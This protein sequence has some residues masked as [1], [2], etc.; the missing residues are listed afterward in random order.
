MTIPKINIDTAL[1]A[2]YW[3]IIWTF[4]KANPIGLVTII[5][6]VPLALHFLV[7]FLR[8]WYVGHVKNVYFKVTLPREDSQKDKEKEVQKDL[9]EKIAIMQQ[10]YR[11]LYELK[12]LSIMNMVRRFLFHSDVISFEIIVEK[13][14][15]NFYV[16]AVE[17]YSGLIEKQITSFYPSAEIEPVEPIY[18]KNTKGVIKCNYVRQR[19]PYWFPIKTFKTIENDPLNAITNI[20]TKMDEDEVGAI[21]IIMRP[22]AEKIA[23]KALKVSEAIFQGRPVDREGNPK[24][25]SILGFIGDLF[26]LAAKGKS[27]QK[28]EKGEDYYQ[29]GMVRMIS[30]KED[31]AKKMGEKSQE[32]NFHTV[33][34]MIASSSTDEKAEKMMNS[35]E[36]AINSVNDEG[37][38]GF[39]VRRTVPID[40]LN[41][42]W[43]LRNFNKR[44]LE[45]R[46]FGYG[47]KENILSEEELATIYHFPDGKYNFTPS[48]MWLSYKKLPVPADMGTEGMLL[49]NNSYRGVVKPVVF[50]KKDRARHQYIIG[51][52]GS[53]KSSLLSYMIRQ[54]IKNGEGICV[55]DPHG[56]LI[57]DALNYVPKERVKD[58]VIFDAGDTDRPMGLNILEAKTAEE[59]DLASSQAT[60]I[61]IKLFGDEIFGPRIQHYFRNACLTL[62]EDPDE[63]AT[64]I[65]VPRIFVDTEFRNYKISK[66][67]NP[68]VLSFWKHEYAETGDREKQEMI[69]YFSAKFGPFITNSIMR[70]T[71]GQPKSAFNFRECMDEGK[72]LLVNLSKGKIG[73][74][75]TQLLGL[76][77]VARIQMA[78]MSRANIPE[79]Q[80][81]DF[82]L[83]V[84]EFQNFATESFASILS[85]ARKYHLALIMA[86]QYISQLVISKTGSTNTQI[87]DAVFGNVGTICAFKVGAEDAEYL[88]KEF[89]PIVTEQDLVGISNYK[90][91]VKLNINNTTSRPFS[92]ETIW[93]KKGENK[94]VGAIVREYAR[95]KYGRKHDF[96]EQ[97]IMAR[98]GIEAEPEESDK[99]LAEKLG[100]ETPPT[101]EAT[102]EPQST[103]Q[104][105][106]PTEP[107][108]EVQ[109]PT[110]PTQTPQ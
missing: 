87:R 13:K 83:Y 51:K 52:S 41:N 102:I 99:V 85:E 110:T 29:R 97:E 81:R 31:T 61:F 100:V 105:A 20:F 44:I 39:V 47:E 92:L 33:I 7:W 14:V 35:M 26:S 74:L 77:M 23:D 89:A 107:Q 70:N 62:M 56:D 58:V 15:I 73:D 36:L 60:E 79:E 104:T 65:D 108:A 66:A 91:Y 37:S 69:P 1:I 28:Q 59:Q 49:G 106:A 80:R 43:M 88:A 57:E 63:G 34:R 3:N 19:E 32:A 27:D 9:K 48:I 18:I 64:L 82:Y 42:P 22:A 8:Y 54:D 103:E 38:N 93:E 50:L 4:T 109:T 98:I 45:T 25:S 84:D 10:C 67:K 76:I 86:H 68:V 5:I 94:K 90:A 72:I 30:S 46:I 6:G 11:S 40:F 24:G 16:V 21:Q 17:Y 2:H 55:I 78:A 101:T 71:I 95:M 53:G 75:N 96:V 12:N